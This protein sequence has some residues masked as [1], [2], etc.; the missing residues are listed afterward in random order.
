[1]HEPGAAVGC[2]AS[3]NVGNESWRLKDV[4]LS[5]GPGMSGVSR[6]MVKRIN[7]GVQ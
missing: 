6:F 5:V 7:E 3:I 2:D 1:M 4:V